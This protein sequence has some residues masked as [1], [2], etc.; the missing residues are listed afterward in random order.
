MLASD[1]FIRRWDLFGNQLGFALSPIGSGARVFFAGSGCSST[2]DPL[3]DFACMFVQEIP[4]R[5]II[6]AHPGFPGFFLYVSGESC[7]SLLGPGSYF[8][9]GT[10][11]ECP[12]C[13]GGSGL[14]K[15]ESA[16]ARMYG[17]RAPF[18]LSPN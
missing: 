11:T 4:S 2:Q 12:S 18:T 13:G 3:A 7:P 14:T 10:C 16:G 17:A 15:L 8:V 1:S 9:G 5:Q 6:Y